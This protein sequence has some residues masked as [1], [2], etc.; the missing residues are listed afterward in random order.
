MSEKL[1]DKE[2]IP[3][4]DDFL[5]TWNVKEVYSGVC[6][7]MTGEPM[8]NEIS[9]LLNHYGKRLHTVLDELYKKDRKLESLGYD[10]DDLDIE[11]GL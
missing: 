4:Y 9:N 6:Y 7:P 5:D 3:F 11:L 8:A 1:N 2:Y 10:L